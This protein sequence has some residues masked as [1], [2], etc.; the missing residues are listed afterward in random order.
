VDDLLFNDARLSDALELQGKRVR[1]AVEA[2]PEEHLMQADAPEWAAA[3]AHEFR[4]NCPELLLQEMYRE[5]AQELRV[6]VY[7]DGRRYFSPGADTRIAGTRIVIRIPFSGDAAL[8]TFQPNSFTSNPPRARVV[9]GELAVA[10]EYP[11][12]T[13]KD[14][15]AT[16]NAFVGTVQQWLGFAKSDIDT[17]NT[18]LEHIAQ[19]AI[20]ARRQRVQLRDEHLAKSSIPER[21]RGQR[22]KTVVA[23]V[24]IRRPAP[25]LPKS[26][27]EG[28]KL[29]PVLEERIFD[30]ILSIV[31]M[32]AAETQRAPD[33]YKQLDEEER[34]DLFL[35]TLNTHYEGRASA[36]A[37]NQSGKTD[38]LI[39][40]EDKNLF[41]AEFKFWSGVRGFIDAIQQLFGYASWRDTKLSLVMFVREKGLTEIIEKA[42][43]ALEGHPR[44]VGWQDAANETE[45]RAKMSSPGDERRHADL[46]VFIVHTPA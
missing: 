9:G 1:D 33:T 10:I 37:F 21:R 14:I 41:I 3:L 26:T 32:Q 13:P 35:A 38:I 19:S 34:R 30:H 39:R 8:F 2:V 17:F 22:S 36:E 23:D 27:V 46:N 15:D 45:L 43:A 18:G 16:V 7:G 28:V 12:D 29:E 25:K 11:N 42:R 20:A 40:L 24:I 31:R 4:A 44:F 6:D 5:K